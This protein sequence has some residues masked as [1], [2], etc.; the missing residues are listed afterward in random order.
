MAIER[1]DVVASTKGGL[2]LVTHIES[3]LRPAFNATILP[4]DGFSRREIATGTGYLDLSLNVLEI[5]YFVVADYK[6][7]DDLSLRISEITANWLA[8]ADLLEG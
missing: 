7:V 5:H 6:N 8:I 1:G 2:F 3:R 4:I